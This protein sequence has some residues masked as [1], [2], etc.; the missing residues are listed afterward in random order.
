MRPS[1]K[2]RNR[3]RHRS[4][5][6]GGSGGSG[7]NPLNR[8]YESNGPDVKVRGTAQTVADKYLQLGRDAQ[9]AGDI[10]TAESYYQYAEHYLRIVAAAQAYTQQQQQQYRRPD[11]EFDDEELEDSPDTASEARGTQPSGPGEPD[12]LGDQPAYRPDSDRQPHQQQQRPPRDANGQQGRDPRRQRWQDR[13]DQP[14][15]GGQQRPPL[16]PR[17]ESQP[18]Q[19][20]SQPRQSESPAPAPSQPVAVPVEVE[21]KWEAPSFLRRPAAVPAPVAIDEPVQAEATLAA[22]D[23]GKPA[24]PAKR[25]YVRKPRKEAAPAVDEAAVEPDKPDVAPTDA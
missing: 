5:G 10:V 20:E 23:A 7:G 1:H 14:R 22:P 13:K 25:S 8:V 6:G 4:S 9:S 11:E 24:A 16:A 15:D 3:T 12:G 17:N 2:N 18:R 21:S 19:N